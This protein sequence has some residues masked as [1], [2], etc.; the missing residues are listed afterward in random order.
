MVATVPTRPFA[1]DITTGMMLPDGVF[2]TMLGTQHIN[3]QVQN[4]GASSI[5]N[6]KLYI[7]SV[8]NPGIAYTSATRSLSSLPPNGTRTEQWQADFSACPSGTHYISVILE[9]SAGTRTRFI[10]KIFVLKTT[11]DPSTKTF[12][13]ET[14]EG[15]LSVNFLSMVK[16][17]RG[18][19]AGIR[20]TGSCCCQGRK[21]RRPFEGRIAHG[22]SDRTLR[23]VN[24]LG[25]LMSNLSQTAAGL[26]DHSQLCLPYYLP[27][28]VEMTWTPTPTYEGQYSDLPFQDPW[29]KILL[30]ILAFL[31]LLAASY[32]ES[33]EGSGE[34]VA[35]AGGGGGGGG[36]GG[37]DSCCGV[38][39]SGHGTSYAAAGLVIL[40]AVTAGIAAMSDVRDPMRRGQDATPPGEGEVTVKEFLRTEFRY[41]E[42]IIPGAPFSAGCKW[43]YKR[44]TD[45]AEYEASGDDLNQNTHVLT[46]YAIS[47]PDVVRSY[48]KKGEWVIRARFEGKDGK[49]FRGP[50]LFVQCF[51]ISPD[52]D[53][54]VLVLQDDGADPDGKGGD[55]TYTA[56]K[57][58][59]RDLTGLWKYYVIAQD[60]NLATPDMAPEEAAQIIGGLV[61]TDQLVITFTEDECPFVPDGHINVM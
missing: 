52:G 58:F 23:G 53:S 2:V 47:A 28:T 9:D 19:N 1:S 22:T 8:S 40:A 29:W 30:C 24:Q 45:K 31:L 51:L 33:T 3:I 7:E 46:N 41:P 12:H 6:P 60:V 48:E 4:A 50:E 26:G 36:G 34:I 39:A 11:F 17:R 20:P 27:L 44:I 10:K 49:L 13:A 43:K 21:S 18:C 56:R 14:P 15:V 57:F 25:A 37:S 61:L 55:G 54:E 35:E 42:S 59:E 38:S 32:V 16:P 5:A